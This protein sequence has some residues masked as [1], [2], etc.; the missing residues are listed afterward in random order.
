MKASMH[1]LMIVCAALSSYV[2]TTGH[3]KCRQSSFEAYL[4]VRGV[5]LLS[6]SVPSSSGRCGDEWKQ[7]ETCCEE[8]SLLKYAILDKKRIEWA[9]DRV[10]VQVSNLKDMIQRVLRK[11]QLIPSNKLAHLPTGSPIK[12]IAEFLNPVFLEDLASSLRIISSTFNDNSFSN[13]RERM[14]SIRSSALCSIC[15]GRSEEFLF[16]KTIIFSSND[17]QAVISECA[18]TL[19]SSTRLLKFISDVQANVTIKIKYLNEKL[20]TSIKKIQS[21]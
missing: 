5:R 10:K 6:S 18:T 2:V 11:R 3:S 19:H 4:K 16:K 9:V 20:S 1:L 7:H 12:D 17:C 13:C 15:S 8:E 21:I 14:I